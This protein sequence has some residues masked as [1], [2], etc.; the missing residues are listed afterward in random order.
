MT[1]YRPG[2]AAD[3]HQTL[4]VPASPQHGPKVPCWPLSTRETAQHLATVDLQRLTELIGTATVLAKSDTTSS[5][6]VPR[7]FAHVLLGLW[8]LSVLVISWASWRPA[9]SGDEA[10][11]VTV[12]RRSFAQVL[13]TFHHD[14]ALG[15]YY[16]AMKAWSLAATSELWLRLPSILAM[17]SAVGAVWVLTAGLAGR[18]AAAFAFTVMLALPAISRYGQ[19][20]RPYAVSLLLVILAV[21][22]WNDDRL[23][24][25][26]G[27]QA[28]L[29]AVIVLAG[30]LHP[31]ALL[32]VPVLVTVSL[33]AP[34][35]E[36][37][38][39][40]IATV[41][42]SSV[43][44]LLL[45]PFLVVVAK[46]AHGQPNPPPVTAANVIE[47]FVRL[48]AGVLSPPLAVV[49]G[50]AALGLAGAGI[51]VGWLRGVRRGAVL[52]AAWLLLPPLILC[53]FQLVTGSSGLVARYWMISLA[54]V[55]IAAGFALDAIWS[56]R[57][58]VAIACILA[59]FALS[60]PTHLSVRTE[61][62]HFG[63]RWRYLSQAFS[64]PVLSD[65]IL[66]AEGWSYRGLVSN[67]PLIATR[68][69]LVV[70]PVPSGRINPNVVSV[71]SDIF[72]TMV[73]DHD[74]VLILQAE[75][76]Y[77]QDIPTRR[78]FRSFRD[79]LRSFPAADVLC[80]Y[81]GEPLG[82]F[83]RT[84]ATL[85]SDDA[86]LLADR[87]AAIAPGRVRCVVP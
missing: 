67:D 8:L 52:A 2:P 32:V 43:G 40:V 51:I 68:L 42:P 65:A 23:I 9:W 21:I 38:R 34:R 71:D 73:R 57:R 49:L 10:A 80:A 87:L 45:S 39:E 66:M 62:G 64:I 6:V 69:P 28:L 20:V 50:V 59:L 35:T 61:D 72:R 30:A 7:H 44:G 31:Y 19:E 54:A 47:E 41:V 79:E 27:R 75:Q 24:S 84:P 37:R 70:D 58:G 14:P 83:A 55:A 78:S 63:Q 46:N 3:T 17:A 86:R 13:R 48:P 25:S 5:R 33:L 85:T 16:L 18:R 56:H 26:K 82:V 12:V 29:A 15:P 11:T 60:I 4:R 77:S 1:A 22:V 53:A 36:R 81:F 74:V 76:G